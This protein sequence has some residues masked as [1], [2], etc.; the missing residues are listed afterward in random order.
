MDTVTSRIFMDVFGQ[1]VVNFLIGCTLLMLS[2]NDF[3]FPSLCSRKNNIS[4]I[5]LHHRYGFQRISFSSSTIKRIF[6]FRSDCSP[7][8]S[9]Q[10]FLPNLKILFLSTTSARSQSVS[11]EIYFS[12]RLSNRFLR[13]DRPSSCGIFG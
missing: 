10:C 7:S 12:I 2:I 8:L 6:Q 13:A 11:L 3:S 1:S 9:L 5:Y 4:S